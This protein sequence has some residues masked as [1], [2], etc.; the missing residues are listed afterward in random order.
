M[1]GMK[2]RGGHGGDVLLFQVACRL[3]RATEFQ[4]R[5]RVLAFDTVAA[6]FYSSGHESSRYRHGLL[7]TGAGVRVKSQRD[8]FPA[9]PVKRVGFISSAISSMLAQ[10]IEPAR[11][12]LLESRNLESIRR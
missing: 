10:Q 5:T 8:S 4:Q 3:G 1:K 11:T 9:H 2:C 12:N 7:S 6:R